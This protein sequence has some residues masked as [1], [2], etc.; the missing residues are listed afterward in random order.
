LSDPQGEWDE[1][2][3]KVQSVVGPLEGVQ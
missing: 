3:T 1:V 2:L